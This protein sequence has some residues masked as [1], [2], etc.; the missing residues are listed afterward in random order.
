MKNVF[1]EPWEGK[2]YQ[3][4]GIF[5]KKILVLGESHYCGECKQCGIKYYPHCDNINTNGLIEQYLSGVKDNWTPTFLKFERSLV[6]KETTLEDSNKIWNSIAFYNYLQVAKD[7]SRQAGTKEEYTEAEQPFWEVLE[8]LQPDLIIVWGMRLYRYLPWTNWIESDDIII[9]GY[10]I[11]N[12]YYQLPCGK[13]IRVIP[14]WH[15]STGYSW[16]WWY[17]VLSTELK[18]SQL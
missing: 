3:T 2:Q 8:C 1:F 6:N 5:G 14:I 16:D 9:D 7:E 11:P 17:K 15:P 12:G 4:G 13:K 10:S 18:N